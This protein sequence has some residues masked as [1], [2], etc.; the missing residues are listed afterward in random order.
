MSFLILLPQPFRR[1][2]QWFLDSANQA[3]GKANWYCWTNATIQQLEFGGWL[4]PWGS[5][6]NAADVWAGATQ[7]TL[8]TIAYLVQKYLI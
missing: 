3:N 7:G 5:S 8:I 2:N 4:F 1:N 6:A